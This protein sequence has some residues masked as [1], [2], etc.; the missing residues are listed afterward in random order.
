MNVRSMTRNDLE[1][2]VS[3]HLAA[4]PSFFLT[5]LGPRFLRLF[6]GSVMTG[7]IALVVTIDDR[8]AGFVVGMLDSRSFYRRLLL[9]RF[10]H[11]A[12]AILPVV[13]RHPSTLLRVAR[14][15]VG[16]A[17]QPS[18][19][20]ELMSLAVHPREQHHGLGRALVDAFVARVREAGEEHLWLIT[21]AADNAA[22]KKFYETLGFTA[23]RAFT[24]SE[25]RALV[26][27]AR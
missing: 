4:F 25:G 6:Y 7:G 14:R 21:D 12:I 27:Y 13:L 15:G 3:I 26:E 20:A 24:N 2:V 22:V 17:F 16:R 18:P 5:F 19:G 10:V 23:R 8:V 9:T 11:V 1:G